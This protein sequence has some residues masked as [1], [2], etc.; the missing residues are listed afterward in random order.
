MLKS[1]A[2]TRWIYDKTSNRV[3]PVLNIAKSISMLREDSGV[4]VEEDFNLSSRMPAFKSGNSIGR[5]RVSRYSMFIDQ[6]I[7]HDSVQT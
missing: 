7:E 6:F 3:Y 4:T 1:S 2:D 5:F